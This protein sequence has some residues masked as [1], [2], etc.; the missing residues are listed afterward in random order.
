MNDPL[1]PKQAWGK[2]SDTALAEKYPILN[3]YYFPDN[4]T[5]A[6]Y[7]TITPVN[8]FR[9]VFNTYFDQNLPLLPDRN[10]VFEDEDNYY[11]FI[12]VTNR[13]ER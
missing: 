10:Y 9:V 13:I 6:L 7:D 3:A 12:E 8:S 5:E 11:K 4:K 2:A 1:P